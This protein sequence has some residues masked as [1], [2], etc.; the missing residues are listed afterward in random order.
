MKNKKI[1]LSVL[2][3]IF[4]A[5]IGGVIYYINKPDKESTLTLLDKQWIES[6]KNKV[7]DF[8]ITNNVPIYSYN[9]SGI[10]F[11][12]LE[13]FKNDTNIEFNKTS[14][15]EENKGYSFLVA[16]ALTSKD[17][18]LGE[19]NY[20]IVSKTNINYDSVNE[21]SNLIV[22]TLST[23]LEKVSGALKGSY[24]LVYKPFESYELLFSSLNL[25]TVNAI[26]VPK[27]YMMD[28]I[29][30]NNLFINYTLDDLSNKYVIHLGD[31]DR[32][33]DIVKKYFNKWTMDNYDD[34]F[35]ENFVN[36]YFTFNEIPEKNIVSFRSKR[37]VYGFVNNAPYD[38]IYNGTLAGINNTLIKSFAKMTNI[39]ITYKEFNNYHKLLDA[40]NNN[41][42]DFFYDVTNNNN[43][44]TDVYKT[45]NFGNNNI[46]I[47]SSL[48]NNNFISSINDLNSYSVLTIKDTN[49]SKLLNDKKI[50][51]DGFNNINAL[52]NNIK[53]DSVIVIDEE[54]YNY[55]VR[56]SLKDFKIDNKF[57]IDSNK[58]T[59]RSIDSNKVFSDF[60]NFY[61]LFVNQN[62]LI[63]DGYQ[64]I[65]VKEKSFDLI[66][67][68]SVYLLA[69]WGILS[70]VINIIKT[71]FKPRENNSGL[72][73]EE[74][75]KYID[76]LT[77]LKNRNYLNENIE[78]WDASEVYPQGIVVVD[79]NNVA[80]INDN[81]GH[82]EGDNVIKEAANVLIKNQVENT[83]IIRT[84][85]NEFLI[86][87]VGYD[88]KQVISYIKKLNK[89][90]KT[91][92]H[93]FGASIGYSI[94]NDAIKTVD[95][96]VNEATIDMRNNK[97][98]LNNN[99]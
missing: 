88:E 56:N 48:K 63:N 89:E 82:N 55:Y 53:E 17:L 47:L 59:I 58:F 61:L 16:N 65:V 8:T 78:K 46:V 74:K 3:V 96:A 22:G 91:L 33:N 15:L 57:T 72:S 4:L 95:D 94:I 90:L 45:T 76:M 68:I 1:I 73:K 10:V 13:D 41:N 85:G 43:F 35:G 24:N 37:Y 7:V 29:I 36:N 75:L 87:M 27:L 19:D 40:F 26:V 69:I 32:L 12:F 77:S 20:A 81:Y 92:A 70:I 62:K 14:V 98:E 83:E 93:G 86:Y 84:N 31:N 2:V 60:F 18:L 42:I 9:G 50:K 80:Y 25:G 39:E 21:L 11:D 71:I 67:N 79:L 54:I 5:L 64:E 51:Y 99:S 49:V 52:L 34:L 97:Q 38:T 23:E 28:K 6:N 44:K 66:K 30:S